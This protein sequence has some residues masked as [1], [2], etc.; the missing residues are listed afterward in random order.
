MKYRDKQ[1]TPQYM[2]LNSVLGDEK[3]IEKKR[4]KSINK[5]KKQIEKNKEKARN[6]E[7]KNK[8]RKP[9]KFNTKYRDRIESIQTSADKKNENLRLYREMQKLEQKNSE[10]SKQDEEKTETKE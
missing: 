4:V 2:Y 10:N 9:S 1:A 7:Q 6:T 5:N 3:K 8:H